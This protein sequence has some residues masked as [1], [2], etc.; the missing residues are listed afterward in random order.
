MPHYDNA[1]VEI[2]QRFKDF[3]LVAAL[4]SV[5]FTVVRTERDYKSV[6][7]IFGT[8]KVLNDAVSA[9]WANTLTVPARQ[10]FEN[11]KMLKSRIY[12]EVS[13]GA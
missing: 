3:G 11:T 8:T 10:Y 4:I 2:E 5:G 1:N 12:D 6:Y 9:Y 7:F 13:H